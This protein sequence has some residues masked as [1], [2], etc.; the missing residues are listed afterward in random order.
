MKKA[1]QW[2]DNNKIEYHFHDYKK[3]GISAETIS[4]WVENLNWEILINKRGTTWRKLE[5]A[6]KEG[7]TQDKAIPLLCEYPS[8]IKRPILTIGQSN[9]LVGFSTEKYAELFIS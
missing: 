7:L 4:F 2:L 6:Q 9:I 5:D 1:F 3:A 8:M